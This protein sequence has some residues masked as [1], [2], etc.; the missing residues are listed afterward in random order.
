MVVN[1]HHAK[2][3]LSKLIALLEKGEEV[4]IARAGT[5]VAK[6]VSYVPKSSRTPN[7]LKGKIVFRD[8]FDSADEEI[9]ALFEG[10]T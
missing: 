3:N 2:T 1:I 5:P 9:E 7:T 10:E 4:I 8:D 6:L